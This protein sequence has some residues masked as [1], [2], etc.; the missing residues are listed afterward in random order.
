MNTKMN[1][2]FYSQVLQATLTADLCVEVS[3]RAAKELNTVE[4]A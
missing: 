1:R 4:L 2:T 3:V